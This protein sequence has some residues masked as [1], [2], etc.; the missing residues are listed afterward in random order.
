MFKIRSIALAT[1]LAILLAGHALVT[2]N[3]ASPDSSPVPPLPR[4]LKNLRDGY[5]QGGAGATAAAEEGPTAV[6]VYDHEHSAGETTRAL[7]AGSGCYGHGS[8]PPTLNWHPNYLV[9]W[10]KGRCHLTVDCNSPGYSTELACCKAAYS[11]QVSG[12]CFGQL[13]NP[14]TTSPTDAGGMVIYYPDY[15]TAWPDAYCMDVRPMPR[16]RPTYTTMMAC[17]KSAYAGQASGE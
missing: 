13:P 16:G 6:A 5:A 12:Y 8:V 10:T 14:P 11:G 7:Q 15:S 9:G 17:C 2:V 3:A 4:R 1:I